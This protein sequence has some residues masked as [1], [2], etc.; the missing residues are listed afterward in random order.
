MEGA[1]INIFINAY[2]A[3]IL[4]GVGI[5]MIKSKKPTGFYTG[6]KA[7]DASEISDVKKWNLYHGLIFIVCAALIMLAA[8]VLI[9]IK[10]ETIMLFI[11]F[12]VYLLPLPIM[13]IIHHLLEKNYVIKK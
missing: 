5:S 1:I 8:I 10:S 11:L 4:L 6:E 12:G 7:H 3:L 9:F 2:V 13:I